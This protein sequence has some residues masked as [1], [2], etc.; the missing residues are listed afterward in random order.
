[1]TGPGTAV[2]VSALLLLATAAA[3]G[4][5]PA[6]VDFNRQ[7]RPILLEN[8]F[9]CHGPDEKA[10]KARLRLDVRE[11]A[12]AHG[13]VLVPGQASRSELIARVGADDPDV[14]MPPPRTGKR[15]TAAQV[16]LLRRWIDEG[17]R[18]TT[19][20]A[21]EPPRRP[22]P[23]AVDNGGWAR[24]PIDAF[25]LARLRRERLRPS[26]EA[27]RR[28]LARRLSL[29]LTGL[30]PRPEA[31][32]A[33]VHDTSAGAYEAYVERL[34][35]SPHHGERLALHWLDLARFGDSDGYHDDTPRFMWQFRD[36]VIDSFNRN[37]PFDRFSVEH[38]AGDLLP[39]A[40]LEQKVGSA[41]HRLGPTS[42][43]G[44]ADATEYLARY[45]VDRV[46]TTAT[47]WLGVT[48]QCAECHDH[49]Y[50]PFTTRE[51]YQLFAFFNQ[52]PED[53][54]YRG[55]DA[56]PVIPTPS[57]PQQAR[58]AELERRIAALE[59]DLRRG[60]EAPDPALDAAQSAWE[61]RLTAGDGG[62]GLRLSDWHGIGPFTE[63][64]GAAPF[65]YAYAPETE[66]DLGK[67]YE[68]GKLRWQ[69]RP[70]WVDGKPHYLHGENCATYAYRT[71]HAPRRQPVTFF[72]GSDD[73]IKVWLNGRLIHSNIL[74]RGVAPNQDVV[75]A[76][77]AAG[78]NRLL[79]KIVNLSGGYG[80][81]FCTHETATD[82]RLEQARHIARTPAAN[83]TLA[84]QARLRRYYRE[85]FAAAVV[86]TAA[87]LAEA[88]Q[89]KGGLERAVPKL[90]VM[91]DTPRRRPT[92]VLRRGDFR[93]PGDPVEPG[94]PAVLGV[95]PAG[96]K[97]DRLALARWL[98]SPRHPLT[99]R[100]VVNRFWQM[101]FGQGL[102]ATANDFGVRGEPPSHPELLDW[103]S[104]EFVASGWDVRH[105]LRLM[106][107][108]ATYRQSSRLTPELRERDPANVLLARGPRFRLPA[109]L[110]RDNALAV[111]GLLQ[112]RIGGPSV[113][114]YQPG[115]LWRELAYG[116]QPDR[117][118][119][120]DHGPDLYRRGLYTFWKR[121][122]HYPAFALFDA[123]SREVC[124]ARRAVT[125][126]PLQAL[127]T[128][129]DLTYVEAARVLAQRVLGEA[130]A[131]FDARLDRAWRRVL[132]RP[133][134]ARE[135]EVMRAVYAR[136]RRRYRADPAAADA[137]ARAGE[138]PRPHDLDAAEHAAWTG[139]CQALLNLDETL[140]RE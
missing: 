105:V 117:A 81:Y 138:Y 11:A 37:K 66:I 70:E 9:A 123:P 65:E 129:N 35:A 128:L 42:S 54:L 91:A 52:V 78:E 19:H 127:V 122:I 134:S 24:N 39:G 72:L 23:P 120:Q 56:P 125:N 137:L 68:G 44:G 29:D 71:I 41:F 77:L 57:R 10:R 1:M 88:R 4:E 87:R 102:V 93:A 76:V 33:F 14:R 136:L 109:E 64:P 48:L 61:P 49:K 73:G 55:N 108:S 20:W 94:V 40:T 114:P 45:A 98:V 36:Y 63:K 106:V 69:R 22:V 5:P 126:T 107:T 12:L 18:W 53:P 97:P 28:T 90:R 133:P 7:I 80:F 38:L 85:H 25:V 104:C 21:Y 32:E 51:F 82:E 30:P 135:R 2:G 46:N 113:K 34:F 59:A 124:T 27:D 17:A 130:G 101:L 26:P 103:L 67:G 3:G 43:E 50:D 60:L 112:A 13:R 6:A 58:L 140:T 83:R 79:M 86:E 96:A 62:D 118:Y 121:S 15:L 75:P 100:V 111:S 74:V 84:Q 31:V 99:A 139:L 132:A 116:D 119:V 92:H 8:C 89:E 115:D 16:D 47:V 131:S 110:V 95:L